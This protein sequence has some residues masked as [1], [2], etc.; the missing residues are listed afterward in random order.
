MHEHFRFKLRRLI[1]KQSQFKVNE[2]QV[3]QT[4]TYTSEGSGGT[5]NQVAEV[6]RGT[7]IMKQ[8]GNKAKQQMR[9]EIPG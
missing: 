7:D 4:T 3:T 5:D 2:G 9:N 8:Q 6:E 1:L